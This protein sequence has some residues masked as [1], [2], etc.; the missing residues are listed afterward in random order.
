MA[1]PTTGYTNHSKTT[2]WLMEST[3]RAVLKKCVS[4]FNFDIELN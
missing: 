3:V 4:L 2:V 1:E